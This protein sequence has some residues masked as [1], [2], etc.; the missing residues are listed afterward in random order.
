MSICDDYLAA[1]TAP[2]EQ[3]LWG[4]T[5][6]LLR[7]G[8]TTTGVVAVWQRPESAAED[9][10]GLNTEFEFREWVVAKA[11]YA[12]NGIESEPRNN[13]RITD[14]DGTWLLLADDRTPAWRIDGE[15]Y[16]IRTKRVA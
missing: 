15:D 10:Q 16:V 4:D 14:A 1:C 8:Q 11:A 5:V 2:E 9:A 7:V 3:R 6:T 12:F 13:D